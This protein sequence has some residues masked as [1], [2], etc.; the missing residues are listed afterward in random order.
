M[1]DFLAATYHRLIASLQFNQH[2]YLYNQFHIR[3][4]LTGLIGPRGVGKTTLL[5]QYIKENLYPNAEVFYFSADN[6]IFNKVTLVE[7]IHHCYNIDGVRIFFIDEIHKYP[8]WSQ[9][10]KNIYDAFPDVKI[11]FS[12]SSSMDIIKGSSDLSRRAALFY[13]HGLSFREY[14]NFVTDHAFEPVKLQEILHHPEQIAAQLS[15][16]KKISGYFQEY[17]AKGYYPFSFED[18]SF[19]YEK[20]NQVLEKTIYEDI[21]NYYSLKTPH[22]AYF[23]NILN[24]LA[25]IPPGSINTHSIA[26]HLQIDDKTAFH[27][28]SI[29]KETGL[30][31]FVQPYAKG[32]Q[33]LNKPEKIF[34]NNTTL[35]YAIDYFLG[36]NQD[37]GSIR[38]LFFLQSIMN[39]G[40]AVFASA[41]ADFQ[42][43]DCLFEIGGKNKTGRQLRDQPMPAFLVKDDILIG[44][45]TTI[46]LLYFGFCY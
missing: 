9:S 34:L 35:Q 40:T 28:L 8:T 23:K 18:P 16:I 43:N 14:L 39:S 37:K 20:I 46:P 13:L 17:L 30:A 41:F 32:K 27:Y 33:L 3:N 38:E 2:R 11:I 45:K 25:S 22:L 42:V 31:R 15:P 1:I 44:D 24:Y 36:M 10:L 29:L 21:A 4:R 6:I 12:G 5:L 7:F 26:K 19:Y